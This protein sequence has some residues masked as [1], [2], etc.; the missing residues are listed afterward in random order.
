MH[1]LMEIVR[2][3]QTPEPWAEGEKIPWNEP[4]F[5]RRMLQ[6]HLSQ[7]HDLASRRAVTIRKH[8]DWIQRAV[9]PGGPSRIL[10]LGC[11]PGLYASRLAKLGHDCTGVD[12]SPASIEYARE[13]CPGRRS[14]LFLPP[15][16]YP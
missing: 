1:D 5:S 10:D 9:L 14:D 3:S 8:V 15:D 13:I 11:G 7:Q 6:E 4:G 12:F 2:R 16:G